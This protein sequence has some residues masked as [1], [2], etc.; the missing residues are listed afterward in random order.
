MPANR[1][2]GVV[3]SFVRPSAYVLVAIG[4]MVACDGVIGKPH[5]DQVSPQGM[6]SGGATTGPGVLSQPCDP[7]QPKLM[8]TRVWRLVQQ[9]VKN[10]LHDVFGFTGKIVDALPAEARLEGY[11]NQPDGL[12]IS[13]LLTDYYF[14]AAD[15][16]AMQVLANAE[17]FLTCP[18]GSLDT[19]CLTTFLNEYGAKAWRRPL[20]D[21]ERDKL[22]QLYT[23]TSQT[24][25]PEI[26][27][28]MVVQGLLLSPNFLFRTELGDPQT[29]SGT[30]TT[31]TDY[32]LASAL[33]YTVWDAPPDAALLAR[34]AS[35]TLHDR[36]TFQAEARR[37]LSAT[38]KV[39]PALHSFIQQWLKTDNLGLRQKDP[40]LFPMYTPEVAA[41]LSEETDRFVDSIVFDSGGDKTFRS[42]LTARYGFVNASTAPLYGVQ[43]TGTG[44]VQ[45]NLNPAERRGILTQAA[46]L[47]AHSNSDKTGVPAR[48]T[49]IRQMILCGAV[50]PPPGNFKFDPSVI[51]DDMTEREKFEIHRRSPVCA[52]CHA[53]FDPLGIAME[54]YDPIGRYRATDK[55]KTIDASGTIPLAD[56]ATMVT[57]TDYVNLIDQLAA[58]SDVYDCFSSQYLQYATGRKLEQIDGCDAEAVAKAFRASA[59]R[60]DELVLGIIMSPGFATRRN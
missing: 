4:S 56:N 53:L 9:Q 5:P 18:V 41:S 40:T 36:A 44:L 16:I 28:R 30:A 47:A 35:G 25:G 21:A 38:P 49:F 19:I 48:G 54:N 20:A 11:A 26:A 23:A 43:A 10:T 39:A 17:S 7:T 31:L 3:V 24:S 13:P 52:T 27:L 33:S 51:T 60:L 34:A 37:L 1:I 45:S 6:G 58:G 42:L 29:A 8:G 46:F 14:R 32:E 15:E 12:G 50:P 57:F 22:I 2:A 55:G 59:Y